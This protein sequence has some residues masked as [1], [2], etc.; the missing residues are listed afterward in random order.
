VDQEHQKEGEKLITR[1]QAKGGHYSLRQIADDLVDVTLKFKS[2][3]E[4]VR[5]IIPL[6]CECVSSLRRAIQDLGVSLEAVAGECPNCCRP[7]KRIELFTSVDFICESCDAVV[8]PINAGASY[9]E[10]NRSDMVFLEPG[11]T[12]KSQGEFLGHLDGIAVYFRDGAYFQNGE[13]LVHADVMRFLDS[14]RSG[15]FVA[16]QKL[17]QQVEEAAFGAIF[18]IPTKIAELSPDAPRMKFPW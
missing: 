2:S 4:I 12:I 10:I 3:G 15:A 14:R 8:K 17:R 9:V 13:A 16:G 1:F 5:V 6:T 11:W 18:G 7:M